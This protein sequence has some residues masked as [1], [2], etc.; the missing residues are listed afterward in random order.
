MATLSDVAS[1]SGVSKGAVSSVLRNQPGSDGVSAETRQRILNVVQE[2]GY[3]PH[4]LAASLRTRK[5]HTIGVV[6]DDPDSYFRH[7]NNALIFGG[8][9]CQAAEMGYQVTVAGLRGKTALDAR[10]M[11]GCVILPWVPTAQLPDVEMLAAR[12]PVLSI[13]SP[14]KGAIRLTGDDSAS[15]R[16]GLRRAAGYLLGLGHRRIAI[17]D[18][19]HPN[20]PHDLRREALRGVARERG[21]E[22]ELVYF[23]DR[24]QERLYAS[25]GEIAALDRTPTAVMAMDDDYARVLIGHLARRGLRV[26]EDVSVFSGHTQ[27]DGFQSVPALTGLALDNVGQTR[28]VVRRLIEIV[29]EGGRVEEIVLPPLAVELVERAS[30][31]APKA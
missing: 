9:L 12:I 29:S 26:P 31:M 20:G 2:L 1:K 28:G 19:Q 15:L 25:A 22:V 10:L 23:T 17:V 27:R 6:I 7:P 16:Q 4:P 30:C 14:V 13:F 24:W 3:R 8:I 11:D 21:V 18:V 5:T